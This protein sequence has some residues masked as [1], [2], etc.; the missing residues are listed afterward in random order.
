MSDRPYLN[1]VPL[2]PVVDK[3]AP[4]EVNATVVE[5]LEYLLERAKEGEITGVAVVPRHPDNQA[6]YGLVGSV[7]GYSMV[8]ALHCLVATLTD[9]NRAPDDDD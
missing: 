8:G 1:V 5:H 2:P 7:G 6:S 4:R 9:L 3:N